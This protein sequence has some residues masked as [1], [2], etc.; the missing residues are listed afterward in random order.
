MVFVGDKMNIKLNNNYSL[1]YT[2]KVEQISSLALDMEKLQWN[3]IE[4]QRTLVL[5]IDF[6][7]IP[8][9]DYKRVIKRFIKLKNK[10]SKNKINIGIKEDEKKVIGYILN[11]NEEDAKKKIL[12][13]Q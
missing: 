12:S 4:N 7:Q 3:D 13:T 2:K 5:K 6:N 9:N 11:Y 1:I 10:A 8:Y